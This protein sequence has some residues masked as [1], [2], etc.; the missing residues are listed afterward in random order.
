MTS[1]AAT[2]LSAT[3]PHIT[4]AV[5]S[6]AL[7][8]SFTLNIVARVNSWAILEVQGMVCHQSQPHAS[9]PDNWRHRSSLTINPGSMEER[10]AGTI[11]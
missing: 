11:G 9:L 4:V 2:L 6:E 5:A 8:T 1:H 10:A 7:E 3:M